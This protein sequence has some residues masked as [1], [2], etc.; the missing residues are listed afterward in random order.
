MTAD[1][2]LL[3]GIRSALAAHADP[4]RAE[5]QQRY[6]KSTLPY[7]GLPSPV[8]HMVCRELFAAHRLP[9]RET[10]QATALA[11]W[12]E[13]T[14]REEW[15]A[16][17]QLMR[18]RPYRDWAQDVRALPI[19]HHVI[20][21]GAWWDVVDEVASHLV[22]DLL[23]AHHGEIAP[24]MRQW[25]ASTDLWL[26]RTSIICQLRSRDDTDLELL[27]EAIEPNLEQTGFFLRKAIGWALRDY[28]RTDP[29]WVRAFVAQ[30]RDRMSG[31][32]VREA[33]KHL[34][35]DEGPSGSP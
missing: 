10:W 5:Q 33:L 24:V 29:A 35:R 28:A 6:M 15:Y 19:Y 4:F 16:A 30:N 34:G 27:A 31:L 3:V 25:A 7:Y 1:E 2:A 20:T 12:D 8:V 22:G 18:Y 14:H 32:T 9:D 17:I 26:R 21:T 23:R 11:L 13:A